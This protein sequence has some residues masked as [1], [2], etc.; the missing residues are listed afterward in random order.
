VT[1]E[2]ATTQAPALIT[3]RRAPFGPRKLDKIK[4]GAMKIRS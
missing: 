3:D 1:A 2:I 4:R